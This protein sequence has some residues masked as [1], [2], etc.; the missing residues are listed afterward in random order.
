MS[1]ASYLA[2]PPRGTTRRSERNGNYRP[3]PGLSRRSL[4][5]R[6]RRHVGDAGALE[7]CRLPRRERDVNQHGRAP[8]LHVPR[9]DVLPAARVVA[10]RGDRIAPRVRPAV[11]PARDRH[12]ALAAAEGAGLEILRRE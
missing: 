8:P 10:I 1:L 12:D 9:C 5:T 2:A 6:A 7:D 4:A 3:G 11:R